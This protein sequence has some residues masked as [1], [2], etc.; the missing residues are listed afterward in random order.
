MMSHGSTSLRRAAAARW[1]VLTSLSLCGA[2]ACST[3]SG[4]WRA[5][6]TLCSSTTCRRPLGARLAS[7]WTWMACLCA[8][9]QCSRRHGEPSRSCSTAAATSCYPLCSS[10]TPQ[11][12][13]PNAKRNSCRPC[14][15]CRCDLCV[16]ISPDQVVLSYSPLQTLT[17]FH[18]KCVLVSGQGP[19]TDI[20]HSLGFKKVVSME[21]LREQYPLLDMVDHSRMPRADSNVAHRFPQIEA[22]LL[23]GEP[24]RW[25]TNLQLLVDVLLTN[26][27]PSAAYDWSPAQL[28]VLACNMDL[29]WMAEAPSPRFGHG[30]FLLCL[31]SAYKKLTGRELSYRALLGKPSLLTYRFAER[32]LMRRNCHHKVQTIYAVGDNPMTDVYGANLYNRYL[33]EQ[34]SATAETAAREPGEGEPDEGELASAA[35]CRSVLVCTG[36]YKPAPARENIF[37]HG[38][39]DMS[40]ESGLL[41]PAYVL[42]DVE[43][44]VD[45]VLRRHL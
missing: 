7:C 40:A 19:I 41:E 43:A 22:V 20:A 26:G 14:S 13:G 36:V 5:A 9:A 18:D 34:H 44:A 3:R 8:A 12:V 17:N 6:P 15:T 21:Q 32:A 29:L 37:L 25:E 42:E 35:R 11:V 1:A 30:M 2:R 31:E 23:F 33:S 27:R 4:Q 45:L 28:P 10:P 38:H 16:Q 39:R 24:V